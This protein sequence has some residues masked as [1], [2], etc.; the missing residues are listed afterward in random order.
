[1]L[2]QTDSDVTIEIINDGVPVQP[3]Q[4]S[5]DSGSGI[6]NL[7]NRVSKLDGKLTTITDDAGLFHLRATIP[8]GRR[9]AHETPSSAA[10]L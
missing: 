5:L 3:Q 8:T 4:R 2:R 9:A 6:Q 7:S 1:V 10:L